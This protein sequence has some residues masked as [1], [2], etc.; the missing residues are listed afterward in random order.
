MVYVTKADGS[1]Q[2]FEKQKVINTC[3]R[4]HASPQQANMVANKIEKKIYEGIPTKQILNMIFKYLKEYRPEIGHQIDLREAISL[5]RPKPDFEQFVALLLKEHGYKV[6]T[7]QIIPGKCVEHEIDIVASKDDEIA[8]V[9]IKHHFQHHTFTSLGVFLEARATFEDL[10]EGYNAGKHKITFS[11][12]LVVCNTKISEHARMYAY[13]RNIDHIGWKYPREHGLEQMITEKKFYPITFLK[14]LD[15][16]SE[17]RLGNI[18]IVTLKQLVE[19]DMSELSRKTDIPE[20]RLQNLI[21][22]AKEILKS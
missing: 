10:V 7:N 9:E 20:D 12:A 22:K 6:I 15:K 3:L 11:R 5:L 1:K 2:L 17:E 16:G 21:S 19:C 4:M 8:Y 18:G 14:T 13:C